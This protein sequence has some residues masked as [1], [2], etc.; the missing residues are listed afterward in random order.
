MNIDIILNNVKNILTNYLRGISLNTKKVIIDVARKIF[1]EKGYKKANIRDIAYAA[2]VSTGAIYGYFDNKE[3]LFE[4]AIGPLPKEYYEKYL[5]AIHK[6]TKDDYLLILKKIKK[7]HFDGIELFLD[8]VY[9]DP[10]A[11]KLVV[12]GKGT[13]YHKHLDIII[14]REVEA[15]YHFINI[16]EEKGHSFNKPNKHAIISLISNLIKDLIQVIKLDLSREEAMEYSFQITSF[17]YQ[18][19][20]NLL[21]LDE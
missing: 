8:Y 4:A 10:I 20:I 21:N 1:L 16:L 13:N 2:E 17:F 14:N 9:A 18:G 7:N 12:M 15:F 6:I 11:W 19:W 5:S 3:K